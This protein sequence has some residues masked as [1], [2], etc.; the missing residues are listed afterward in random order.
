MAANLGVRSESWLNLAVD[1]AQVC[2]ENRTRRAQA[3]QE[4]SNK[5]TN[6]SKLQKRHSIGGDQN[7]YSPVC[8]ETISRRELL[9]SSNSSLAGQQHLLIRLRQQ[10]YQLN[11]SSTATLSSNLSN[12]VEL[13]PTLLIGGSKSKASSGNNIGE[14]EELEQLNSQVRLKNEPRKLQI[15]KDKLKRSGRLGDAGRGEAESSRIPFAR[16]WSSLSE[17]I[18]GKLV[19]IRHSWKHFLYHYN[20]NE[21]RKD[22]EELSIEQ[23]KQ[24]SGQRL[25]VEALRSVNKSQLTNDWIARHHCF[26]DNER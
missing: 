5:L 7:Y 8:N 17:R 26:V 22:S 4:S 15:I 14:T 2:R 21:T 12:S 11:R 13:N 10:S 1:Q 9:H 25:K 20:H 6:R 18:N 24:Q 16:S 23:P 19:N 3:T